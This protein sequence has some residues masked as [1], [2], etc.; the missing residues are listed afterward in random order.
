VSGGI[1]LT[2]PP[3]EYDWSQK[4]EGIPP[5]NIETNG[6]FTLCTENDCLVLSSSIQ[7]VVYMEI[8]DITGNKM[9]PNCV[10]PQLVETRI[11]TSTYPTG[12]YIIKVKF[13]D[14]SYKTLKWL[15]N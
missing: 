2:T 8:T 6:K 5:I 15:K 7:P 12:L 3:P 9:N 10:L 14:G 13:A 11:N 4:P 1:F